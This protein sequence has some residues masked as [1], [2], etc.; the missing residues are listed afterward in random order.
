MPIKMWGA[1]PEVFAS[2]EKD[3]K[4]YVLPPV[5]FR[6][7]LHRKV[8][9]DDKHPIF[10]RRDNFYVHEDG[11]AFEVSVRPADDWKELFYNLQE[12]Y[13]ALETNILKDHLDV[14]DGKVHVS[15]TINYEWERWIEYPE[16]FQL[17]NLF[18]CDRDFDA[19]DIERDAQ[20]QHVETHPLRY[21]GGHIHGSGSDKALE[22]PILAVKLLAMTAGCAATAYSDVPKLEKL[23]TYLYGRPGRFRPQEYADGTFGIE[24]RTPSNTWTKNIN[25]AEKVFEWFRTGI[26]V[27]L[28]KGLGKELLPELVEPTVKAILNS[29][30]KL[31]LQVLNRIEERI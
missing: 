18:G 2:Y 20:V 22:D 7:V 30:Q 14:C 10:V 8:E 12:S 21:G 26:D 15:P 6:H 27:L 1:D 24:Y 16:E 5:Y 11:V 19:F 23:R 9:P 13:K 29:N 31:A 4:N 3:G 28:E 25:I 17:C